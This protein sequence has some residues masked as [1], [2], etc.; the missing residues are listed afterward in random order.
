M[1][2]ESGSAEPSILVTQYETL[3]TAAVGEPL[4]P[5]ARTGLTLFLRRG[6]WGWARAMISTSASRQPTRSLSSNW[7]V[8]EG[9]R[10]IIHLFAAMAINADNRGAIP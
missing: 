10:A 3:R 2:A 1:D 8:P 7:N 6:M 5:E 4:P 9:Y